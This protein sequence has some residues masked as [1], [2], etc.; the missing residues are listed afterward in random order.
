MTIR[1]RRFVQ[2]FSRVFACVDAKNAK[3]VRLHG[4]RTP[5]SPHALNTTFYRD[6][7]PPPGWRP[8]LTL[9]E[10]RVARVREETHRYLS[11][12]APWRHHVTLTHARDVADRKVLHAFRDWARWVARHLYRSHFRLGYV[13]A[14]Q[15]RDVLHMH[16]LVALHEADRLAAAPE[17]EADRLA[18]A[19][20]HGSATAT[21]VTE[22]CGAAAYL[23]GHTNLTADDIRRGWDLNVACTRPPSCRRRSCLLAPGAWSP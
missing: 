4:Y 16:V 8:A 19:W 14:P 13:Y 20:T 15:A 9:A 11:H 17:H 10:E 1:V 3:N 21:P 7:A 18:A 5:T 22:P 2:P 23:L 12:V 6:P